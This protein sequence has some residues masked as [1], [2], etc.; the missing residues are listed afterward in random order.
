MKNIL[1][2]NVNW[3]GDVVLSSPIFK[4]LKEQYPNAKVSCLGPPRV[5]DILECIHGV[6][7]VIVYDEKGAHLSI[8]SKIKLIYE[9]SSMKFDIVF[10]LHGSFTRA[11]L[12]FLAGIPKR[13]G[14][15]TKKRSML[16]T[17]KVPFLG[18]DVHRRDYYLNVIESFG[19]SV[20]DRATFIK[21]DEESQS[22]VNNIFRENNVEK[23]DFVVVVN[24]GGNWDLKRWPK[25]NF[26]ILI[27]RLIKEYKAKVIMS[28]SS[29]DI[30]LTKEICLDLEYRPLILAGKQK[31]KELIALL[32]KS[33]LVISADSGPIHLASSVGVK[34][35]GIF[36]PTRPEITGPRGN[37]RGVILQRDVG[38]NREPCY[39]LDCND[40]VCM[41]AIT[42]EDI[43]DEVKKVKSK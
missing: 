17:H 7:S 1:V 31:L 2:V 11:L 6:D 40:N 9:I 38:C 33:D 21:S 41:K 10:L 8:F 29:K 23:S 13:V 24:V 14:Y 30:E 3:I 42:V 43:I 19:V 35:V 26:S 36:G 32:E 16:L 5:K 28:G 39:H 12:V 34:V 22:V 25:N 18:K 20:R 4:A 37:E 15:G 27:D